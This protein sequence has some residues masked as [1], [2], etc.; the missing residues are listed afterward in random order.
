MKK[1]LDKIRNVGITKLF[2]GM[3]LSSVIVFALVIGKINNGTCSY[4]DCFGVIEWVFSVPAI[5]FMLY[6]FIVWCAAIY[7]SISSL[8]R[9]KY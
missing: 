2:I 1:I 4:F 6:G 8:F 3:M 9:K 7:N 5:L